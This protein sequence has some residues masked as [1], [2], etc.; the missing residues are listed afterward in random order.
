MEKCTGM[1]KALLDTSVILGHLLD[2]SK[3]AT[4]IFNNR[5]IEKYTN[6]YALMEVYHVL[7]HKDFSELEISYVIDYIR[8]ECIILPKPSKSEMKTINL[9]DK[10]DRPFVCSA[11][12]YNLVLYIDDLKSFQDA[13]KYVE[14]YKVTKNSRKS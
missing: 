7:K 11:K 2:I 6:E 13:K 3:E 12:K 5:S 8:D 10:P 14:V 4:K 1:I 9:R